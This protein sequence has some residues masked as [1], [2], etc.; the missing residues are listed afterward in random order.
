MTTVMKPTKTISYLV[1][2]SKMEKF[3]LLPYGRHVRRKHVTA[4]KEGILQGN[5]LPPVHVNEKD[6]T[7]WIVDGQHRMVALEQVFK[8]HPRFR[9]TLTLV[10]YKL[11]THEDIK[12]LYH[13]L[14]NNIRET[15]TDFLHVHKEEIFFYNRIQEELECLSV[16]S[17]KT[18]LRLRTLLM[19]YL[20]AKKDYKGSNRM[21][22]V[23]KARDLGEQDVQIVVKFLQ[24]FK[25]NLGNF[26]SRNIWSKSTPFV[27]LFRTY[28]DNCIEGDIPDYQFWRDITGKAVTAP[29]LVQNYNMAGRHGIRR[30]HRDLLEVMNKKKKKNRYVGLRGE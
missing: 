2:K 7:Y 12:N 13:V 11:K 17:G 21:E 4:I 19:A 14:N 10:V 15:G 29:E 8:E 28:Y 24:D 1:T 23:D 30:F 18:K 26:G 22:I 6:G 27:S 3:A 5:Q 16:Y 25:K 9:V 20:D